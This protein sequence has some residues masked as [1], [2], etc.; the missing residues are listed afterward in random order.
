MEGTVFSASSLRFFYTNP[1]LRTL[2]FKLSSFERHI[3]KETF[4]LRCDKND[5]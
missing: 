4:F 3:A 5:Y 1:L 2:A